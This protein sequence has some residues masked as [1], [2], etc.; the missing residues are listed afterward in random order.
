LSTSGIPQ[1]VTRVKEL[2]T[3]IAE[4][5]EPLGIIVTKYQANSTVH[6]NTIKRLQGSKDASLFETRIRQANQIAAAAEFQPYKRTLK[7]KYGAN[8][9]GL[10]DTFVEL[11][12]EVIRKLES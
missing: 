3:E 12:N 8:P 10:A 6:N 4:D 1:I 7:Q 9:N 5:I 2:A 11:A